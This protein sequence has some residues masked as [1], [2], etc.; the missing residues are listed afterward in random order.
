MG[1]LLKTGRSIDSLQ[2]FDP[3][4]LLARI[5]T[6]E[7]IFRITNLKIISNQKGISCIL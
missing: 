2:Y 1:I 5:I 4:F 3:V 7:H 6:L